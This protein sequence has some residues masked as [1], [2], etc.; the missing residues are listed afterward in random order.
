MCKLQGVNYNITS[1]LDTIRD[2]KRNWILYVNR[3]PVNRMPVTDFQGN[4]NYTPKGS[5]NQERTLKRLLD[6]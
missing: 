3:M 5:R 6:V 4:K 2:H 1:V